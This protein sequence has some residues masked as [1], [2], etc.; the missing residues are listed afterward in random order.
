MEGQLDAADHL[1]SRVELID[2][3]LVLAGRD[4]LARRQRPASLRVGL[5]I[6]R[7][8][9]VHIDAHRRAGL[10]RRRRSGYCRSGRNRPRPCRAGWIS[11]P[12]TA[13]FWP[14]AARRLQHARAARSPGS[15]RRAPA[16]PGPICRPRSGTASTTDPSPSAGF[17]RI[18]RARRQGQLLRPGRERPGGQQHPLAALIRLGTPE[19]PPAILHRD[20]GAGRGAAG[21]HRPAIRADMHD[22]EARLLRCRRCGRM[23][24][25]PRPGAPRPEQPER[26]LARWLARRLAKWLAQAG[27]PTHRSGRRLRDRPP[28]PRDRRAAPPRWR[29]RPRRG[30]ARR[31]R[32]APRHA[33]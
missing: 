13:R 5:R 17:A 10:G 18:W 29:S 1:A 8:P 15:A 16:G 6:S 2:A 3:K 20:L 28:A 25:R 30:A 12:A 9:V 11:L 24:S 23:P 4:R 26:R 14:G 22:I 33:R 32:S 27:P 31:P 19:L 21:D 7:W